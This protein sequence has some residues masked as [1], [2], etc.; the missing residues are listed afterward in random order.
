MKKNLIL[1]AFITG[2]SLLSQLLLAVVPPIPPEVKAHMLKFIE[3]MSNHSEQFYL[4]SEKAGSPEAMA[5]AI[6]GYHQGV[7]PLIE[8]LLKLK[9]KHAAFFAA[10]DR[11]DNKSSGDKELDKANEAFEKRMEKLGLAMGKAVQW[12]DNPKVR[13]AMDRM[14]QTMNLLDDNDEDEE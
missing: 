5:K 13:A 11:E 7:R 6:D 12:L 14:Q 2:I 8:G 10:A 3:Q 9:A 4:A 1:I